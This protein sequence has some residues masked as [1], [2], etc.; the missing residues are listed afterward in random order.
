MDE[1]ILSVS[2]RTELN[3]LKGVFNELQITCFAERFVR[4]VFGSNNRGCSGLAIMPARKTV[5]PGGFM[6]A[7]RGNPPGSGLSV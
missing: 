5:S 1:F 3:F 4:Q 6:G 7:I 2:C